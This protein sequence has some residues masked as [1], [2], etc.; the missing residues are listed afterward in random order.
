M[1]NKFKRLNSLLE[2]TYSEIYPETVSVVNADITKNMFEIVKNKINLS[3]ESKILDAGCGLGYALGIFKNEGIDYVGITIGDSDL[4]YCIDNGYNVKK[5][6]ISFL[7]FD[8]N[9]FDLIWARHCLEHSI[10]PLY[11]LNEFNRVLKS[12]GYCYIEVPAPNTECHHEANP[13]HYSV[14]NKDM[15]IMLILKSGFEIIHKMDIKFKTS[16]NKEDKYF[17][18]IVR[19]K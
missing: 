9:T 1:E 6:D 18:F 7:D 16:E 10:F 13:N 14:F 17:C 8:D 19:K 2:K 3:K 12:G 11:T 5:M 4:K 15:I